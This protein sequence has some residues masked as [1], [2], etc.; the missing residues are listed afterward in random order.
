VQSRCFSWQARSGTLTLAEVNCAWWFLREII[1]LIA[2]S[3][4]PVKRAISL[5]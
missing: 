4:A 5:I 2:C 1:A 3:R